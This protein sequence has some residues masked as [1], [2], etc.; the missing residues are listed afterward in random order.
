[1]PKLKNIYWFVFVCFLFLQKPTQAQLV[2]NN[3]GTNSSPS[4]LVTNVLLGSGVTVSNITFTGDSTKQIGYF[5]SQNSN[6]GLNSGVVLTTG[7]VEVGVGP[8]DLADAASPQINSIQD[9][10]ISQLLG[11]GIN[12]RDMAILE[13]DFVPLGDSV[14]FRYVFASEEYNEFVCSNFNDVF[15]FFI[16][17][18]GI[19]GP[20]QN[21]AKNIALIPNTTTPVAIN[22]VNNGSPG[23][24]AGGGSCPPGGLANAAY[25]IDNTVVTGQNEVQYDGFTVVLEAKSQVICN[26]LYHIKM[27]IADATDWQYDSGVF[28]EAESFYSAGLN[29]DISNVNVFPGDSIPTVIEGCLDAEFTFSRPDTAGDLTLPYVIGGTAINGVDYP[30]LPGT[31]TI[32]AGQTTASIFVQPFADGLVEGNEIITITVFNITPCGDTIPRTAVLQ[33]LDEYVVQ[34]NTNPAITGCPGDTTTINVVANGG[35]PPYN[36]SWSN[37]GTTQSVD[38]SPQ[39]NTTYYISVSDQR[40]CTTV[41][42]VEVSVTPLFAVNAGL[43]TVICTGDTVQLG[44]APTGPT[45]LNYSWS[46]TNGMISAATVTNPLVSPN[47]TVIYELAVTNPATGCVNRD[48]VVV[49]VAVPFSIDAGADISTCVNAT[50]QLGGNPTGPVGSSYSWGPANLLNNATLANPSYTV[51]GNQQFIV[52]VTN[53]CTRIDT[54]NVLA[55]QSPNAVA[56]ND[57]T[58]CPNDTL[59]LGGPQNSNYTY[60]WSILSGSAQ[61]LQNSIANPQLAI[62]GNASGTILVELQVTDTNSCIGLDTI[63]ISVLA[64]PQIT[65]SN[66]TAICPGDTAQVVV[67]GGTNYSWLPTFGISNSSSNTV[68]L[69][70][71]SSTTYIVEVTAA[72]G[73]T[74]TAQYNLTVYPPAQLNGSNDLYICPGDTLQVNLTGAASYSW[75]P[76]YM[77]SNPSIANPL[78]YSLQ[79]TSYS[80]TATSADGCVTVDTIALTVNSAVPTFAGIDT[81]ICIGDTIQI[82]GNPTSPNGTNYTWQGVNLLNANNA[83]PLVAPVAQAT[84]VVLTTNDTCVGTDTVVVSVNA[85]PTVSIASDSVEICINDSVQLV[86]TGAQTY[87]WNNATSLSNSAVNSPIAGPTNTTLY[88]VTGTDA[89]SCQNTDSI[90]VKVNPLPTVQISNDTV[91]CLGDTIVLMVSGGT[92]YSWQ[93]T[94]NTLGANTT[95][96]TVFPTDTT[97]YIAQVTDANGCINF[98]SVE[99]AVRALP[100]VSVSAD[101]N[102][103][104]NTTLQIFGTT[105]V[106]F[107]WIDTSQTLQN[108]ASLSPLASPASSSLYVLEAT[109]GVCFNYDSVL[110]TVESLPTVDA[111]ANDTICFGEFSVLNASGAQS[112]TWDASPF[113][114][115][116]TTASPVAQPTVSS[117]FYVTGV[118][119]NLCSNRDS[120]FVL[121]NQLPLVN[122][123][124]DTNVCR[125][126]T[127]TLGGSPLSA[128][129][130]DVLWLPTQQVSN[131]EA[132]N[133]TATIQQN[134]QFTVT[135]VDS[136]LCSNSAAIQVNVFE[137]ELQNDTVICEFDSTV[138]VP[139]ITHG[140]AP[141]TFVWM[142]NLGSAVNAANGST[143]IKPTTNTYYKLLVTDSNNCQD[144]A[145]VWVRL[146]ESPFAA[147]SAIEIPSCTELDVEFTNEGF[148]FDEAF[149]E[150]SN[151]QTASGNYAA[152]SFDYNSNYWAKLTL[153][154]DRTG[155]TAVA[156]F[157]ERSL[158]L[159]ELLALDLPKVFTPNNDGVNDVFEL[160]LLARLY[161]CSS[162]EIFNRWGNL[163]HAKT[164]Y[165]LNWDGTDFSGQQ[166][167][168]GVYFYVL[169]VNEL[170]FKGT[171]TLLRN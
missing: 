39:Q 154:N 64:L 169:T 21:G 16:S 155:C 137:V 126:A 157:V 23:S 99:V 54:I 89:N 82:G 100:Q 80:I 63:A 47:S 109:D 129:V 140:T 52:T 167:P 48:T 7:R 11:T 139:T 69:F 166:A 152:T 38:V 130:F 44:G 93:P 1:M 113:L 101:T 46:P 20:F 65:I 103:C 138:L 117:Y 14:V 30:N 98:D 158:S 51:T 35:T 136:N 123:G 116:L 149:W 94:V 125:G 33:L 61:L 10:D 37:G 97:Q 102:I 2:I 77:I 26:Q 120:V 59:L 170:T 88:T 163:I 42:S 110:V 96:L 56:G 132:Q 31:I 128:N 122:A 133:P 25:F 43:D 40:S 111:G 92:N 127:I 144:S 146:K 60:Q 150:F 83:N 73:C 91:L 162:L 9:P 41:D 57:T 50:V 6:I 148:N 62:Q 147:I 115:G 86:A 68:Q 74:D 145:D 164:G 153:T 107:N 70:S 135:V 76:N 4:A 55:N 78:L 165:N 84:Y 90:L 142:P 71:S 87:V 36:F 75:S 22:T 124:G 161:D 28:L 5:D 19:S 34:T 112:Y 15:G 18:P 131:P 121:V 29:V 119:T 58:V 105:A 32:P 3:S 143:Q 134:T 13:F 156:N 159:N 104:P 79:D 49:A 108:V 168:N 85:L 72:N 12:S 67:S 45:G 24:S 17:G 151:G 95:T 160:P 8:N 81:A 114:S 106:N 118:D 53:G 141:F 27:A 171:I 66:D